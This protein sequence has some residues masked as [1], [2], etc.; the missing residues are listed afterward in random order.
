M[1]RKILTG[2]MMIVVAAA[3]LTTLAPE[4][5]M[6]L[7]GGNCGTGQILGFKPWFDGLCNESN[8]IE[9]PEN[10]DEVV[11]FVWTIILNVLFDL[12][13][14][15]GYIALGLVIYGGYL[16]IMSQ[17]DPMRMARGKKTLTS[18]VIG[19]AIAML[20]SVLVNTFTFILGID[21]SAGWEQ[22]GAIDSERLLGVFNWAYLMA[23]MVAVVFIIKSGVE[24]MLSRGSPD[25]VRKATQGIIYA[26]VGL[27]IV[28][29]AAALTSFI[30]SSI[31]GAVSVVPVNI[32]GGW[33]A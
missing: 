27:I 22:T 19:A 4:P 12:T 13:I 18:A 9:K 8:E 24:Y 7:G 30:L 29:A 28:L 20:A 16:Y 5:A 15:I 31:S 11:V 10:D 1:K 2:L 21:K 26:A 14:A 17:G 6:A 32:I 33:L 25:K 3:G 23:G